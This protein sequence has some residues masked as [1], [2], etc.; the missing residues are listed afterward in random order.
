[1]IVPMHKYSFIVHHLGYGQFI[2][3]LKEMGVV[4]I[5]ESN[6]EL[7]V[8]LQDDIRQMNEISKTIK[9]LQSVKDTADT[10][11]V[12][13]PDSG[14]D[15]MRKVKEYQ[16]RLG[17][18]EHQELSFEKEYKQLLPWGDFSWQNID[19]LEDI[20]L[21][22]RFY[23]C[24]AQKFNDEWEH[25]YH[26]EKI[27]EEKGYI[28]F[29][30]FS[31]DEEQLA[32]I[33]ADE[34]ILPRAELN[35]VI[36]DIEEIRAEKEKVN[37]NLS[38]LS[39]DGVLI[40]QDYLSTLIDEYNTKKVRLNTSDEVEG[41]IKILEGWVPDSKIDVVESYLDDQ[42]IVYLHE[43]GKTEDRPPVLLKNNKFSR[44]FEMIGN[45]YSLP[46]YGE[47][48]LT[49][50]LA[51]FYLLFFG[52]CF[53][54]AGYGLL[55]VLAGTILKMKS[56]KPQPLL[57]LIQLLGGSTML[58]GILGGTFFGIELYSTNLPVYRDIAQ[59]YG[60]EKH[61]IGKIIQDIMFKAS[62]ALGLVQILFGMF[63]KAVKISK[64]NGFKYAISTLCWAFLII[65]FTI[66]YFVSG[67]EKLLNLPFIIVGGA[68][69][70]GIF[71]LNSPGKS[72]FLNFGLGLWDAY[73]TIVGGVGDLLSYVRL[74]ALGL[75]SAILGLV[76]NNLGMNFIN[77]EA[78]FYLQV[79]GFIGMFLIMVVGHAINIFMSGLGSMVHPLRLTFVEFYKNA[80]F[81]GGGKPYHPFKKNTVK[82]INTSN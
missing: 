2:S 11:Q 80:G 20:G 17:Q 36:E 12:E 28:Y 15:I 82:N 56:D 55:F 38:G 43:K 37:K 81:E 48:D 66:N 5:I 40:L 26:I 54:D 52:F 14:E 31:R 45:L 21:N 9:F 63:I 7:T 16:E 6:V 22:I 41:A 8:S 1:M 19:R 61:P 23:F 68:L 46:N 65:A 18:L 77:P 59:M 32:D 75:A 58:F 44:L 50:F 62:L 35:Q 30:V 33:K 10:S 25:L 76:F 57:S 47:L 74:F 60:S 13:I 4:H 72:I 70:I 69:S 49:P 3:D 34:I 78:D 64:Q 53:S 27:N 67:S 24:A 39:V 29:I 73:N 71:F 42:Q 51:P 79:L